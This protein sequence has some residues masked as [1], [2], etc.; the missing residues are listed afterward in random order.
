MTNI[1]MT[2]PTYK[3]RT[4]QRYSPTPPPPR[5]NL[6]KNT[7]TSHVSTNPGFFGTLIQGYALGMGSSLGHRTV[8]KI[9]SS[10]TPD[11]SPSNPSINSDDKCSKLLD[12]YNNCMKNQNED[13]NDYYNHFVQCS[14]N[15]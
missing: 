10:S 14:N 11:I 4:R 6:S 7:E 15:K 12:L 8:D 9:F 13:C 3:S 1:I 2:K 5:P